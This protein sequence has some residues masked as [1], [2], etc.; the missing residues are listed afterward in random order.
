MNNYFFSFCLAF[1]Y[2]LRNSHVKCYDE[3]IFSDPFDIL[4]GKIKFIIRSTESFWGIFGD[5]GKNYLPI[6]INEINED[7][8]K[9]GTPISFVGLECFNC[10]DLFIEHGDWGLPIRI[11]Q[12]QQINTNDTL[13]E[14]SRLKQKFKD[15]I[16]ENSSDLILEI[17]GQ[18]QKSKKR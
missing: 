12:I 13:I 6:D 2:F 10:H 1:I 8:L 7:L 3:I 11:Q 9:D 15:D 17:K 16:K 18:L 4:T 5:D 14:I